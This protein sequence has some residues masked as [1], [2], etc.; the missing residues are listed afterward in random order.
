MSRRSRRTPRRRRR[1]PPD[2]ELKSFDDVVALAEAERDL[3]FKHALLSRCGCVHFKPG[4]IEV[5]PL[6]P[7]PRDLTQELMRSSRPGPA[8][9]GSWR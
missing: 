5:N 8:A 6:P 3:K 2:L 9:C 4:N 1:P 7:A